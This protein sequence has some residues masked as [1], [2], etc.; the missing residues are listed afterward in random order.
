MR[1]VSI[2]NL[3]LDKDHAT[4]MILMK[5]GNIFAVLRGVSIQVIADWIDDGQITR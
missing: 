5:D 1:T 4:C 2:Q 3:F